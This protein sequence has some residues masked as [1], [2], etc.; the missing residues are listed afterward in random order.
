[1][2]DETEPKNTDP[3]EEKRVVTEETVT[4]VPQPT[5]TTVRETTETTETTEK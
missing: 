1:M 5:E 3:R 2:F 4:P